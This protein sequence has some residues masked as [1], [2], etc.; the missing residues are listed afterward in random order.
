MDLNL[1]IP[2]DVV[3]KARVVEFRGLDSKTQ[4]YGNLISNP[5]FRAQW[6]NCPITYSLNSNYYRC[7][8]WKDIEWDKSILLLGDS[9]AFGLGLDLPSTI[10]NKL[11]NELGG[12]PVV[13]LGQ[14]G[15]SWTFAWINSVRLVEAGIRPL[16]V[17]YIWTDILR[18]ARLLNNN[19]SCAHGT[20]DI[21]Q[22]GL[23][24]EYALDQTHSKN[25]SI[26]IL[27]SIRTMWTCPQLH[28]TWSPSVELPGVQY[29]GDTEIDKARDLIHPGP[30]STAQ[31]AQFMAQKL[32]GKIN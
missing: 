8:E 9:V 25:M 32:S 11:S 29:I 10:A 12:T 4:Y 27:R 13:N 21:D 24:R 20:W 3:G 31:W 23:G 18:Y 14:T 1:L 15:T 28:Y 7:P 2:E 5:A 19:I 30:R 6:A 26:E 16:A 17:I 22:P